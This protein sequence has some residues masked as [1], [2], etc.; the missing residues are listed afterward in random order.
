MTPPADHGFSTRAIHAGQDPDAGTGAVIT[1]IYQVSTYKQDGIGGFRGGYEYSPLGQPHPHRARGVPRRARGWR[2]RVR[3]RLRPR[4]SGHR[5]ARAADPGRPRRRPRRRVR[6]HLPPVQPGGSSRRASSTRSRR[7]ATSTPC[8]PRSAPARPSSSGSRPRPTRCWASP[9]SPAW[10]TLRTPPARCWS[11]TTRSR[12]PTSSSRCRSAPTS[13]RT[14][15]RSTAAVTP[16]SSVAPWSS[17][18]T[19]R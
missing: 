6:R 10:P 2:A 4:R 15:R 17:A 13:S 19:S 5:A 16:T 8:A 12:R 1:P 11:S 14:R 18:A 3:L 9:T 7:W